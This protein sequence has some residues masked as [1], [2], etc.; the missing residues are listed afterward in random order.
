MAKKAKKAHPAKPEV[1]KADHAELVAALK[2]FVDAAHDA[3]HRDLPHVVYGKQVL[4]D[5]GEDVL[6]LDSHGN[7]SDPF[8]AQPDK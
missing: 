3:G 1:K 7:S 5:Y 2:K 6:G 4:E 8:D